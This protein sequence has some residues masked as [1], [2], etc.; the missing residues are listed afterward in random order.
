[1][2]ATVVDI[3]EEANTLLKELKRDDVEAAGIS[4]GELERSA[5][6][7]IKRREICRQTSGKSMDSTA[8]P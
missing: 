7:H 6:H 8:V 3:F 2:R 5:V 1:M 4:N